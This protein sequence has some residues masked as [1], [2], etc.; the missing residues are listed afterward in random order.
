MISHILQIALQILFKDYVTNMPYDMLQMEGK[1]EG[2]Q[3]YI[4]IIVASLFLGT[5]N[6]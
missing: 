5:K 2:M 4:T 6:S 3:K 1:H